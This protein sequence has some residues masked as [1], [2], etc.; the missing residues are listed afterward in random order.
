MYF[1]Y[2]PLQYFVDN[3]DTLALGEVCV[4]YKKLFFLLT[5][6]LGTIKQKKYSHIFIYSI[7]TRSHKVEQG[8]VNKQKDEFD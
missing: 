4:A 2:F 3:S 5:L 1:L 7:F 8:C 6:M